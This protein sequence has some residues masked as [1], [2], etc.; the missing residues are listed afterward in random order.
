MLLTCKKQ[1]PALG[2]AQH[3][4][5]VVKSLGH[6]TTVMITSTMKVQ[7]PNKTFPLTSL[8]DVFCHLR[9]I[10]GLFPSQNRSD[11]SPVLTASTVGWIWMFQSSYDLYFGKSIV[12]S[13]YLW[14]RLHVRAC[15]AIF[16]NCWWPHSVSWSHPERQ[17]PQVNDSQINLVCK[18]IKALTQAVICAEK[19]KFFF[20]GRFSKEELS[21]FQTINV[22]QQGKKVQ[23]RKC[24][25]FDVFRITA[26]WE[27]W[28]L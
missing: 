11:E 20:A 9:V 14:V 25:T 4:T 3:E 19:C 22:W 24:L 28:R 17:H 18:D 6:E 16:T 7:K 1:P 13:G 21:V 26:R 5:V 27:I 8:I 2:L 15:L 10:S 12:N 23:V